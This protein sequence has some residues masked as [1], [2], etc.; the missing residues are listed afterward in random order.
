MDFAILQYMGQIQNDF[1]TPIFIFLT[2]IGDKGYIWIA[3]SLLFLLR[4]ETRRW[5][6]VLVITLVLTTVLGE[7]VLKHLIKRERPFLRYAYDLLIE[8]PITTSF[9]SGHTAAS[10]AVLGV[11]LQYIK[12]YRLPIG[13]LAIGIAFSRLYLQVHYASDV[14]V[15]AMLGF[16]VSYGVCKFFKKQESKNE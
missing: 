12:S 5:G 9:P 14:L 6:I 16:A 4:K 8:Q 1:L 15:G 11:F 10:M 3:L 13:L 2:K 7:G